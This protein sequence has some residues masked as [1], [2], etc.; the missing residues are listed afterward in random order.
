[1]G[2][3]AWRYWMLQYIGGRGSWDPVSFHIEKEDK[4]WCRCSVPCARC[5]AAVLLGSLFACF[6]ARSLVGLVFSWCLRCLG[7]MA[8]AF[9]PCHCIETN[10]QMRTVMILL[11]E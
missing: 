5:F 7:S 6:V 4:L 9:P 2:T 3:V 10:V 11:I 8:V 1:M